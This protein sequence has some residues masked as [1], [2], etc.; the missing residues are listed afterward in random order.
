LLRRDLVL[1]GSCLA[2]TSNSLPSDLYFFASANGVAT[3][4]PFGARGVSLGQYPERLLD[5]VMG[6][7]AIYPMFPPRTIDDFPE[8]EESIDLVDGG[9]AH[10][11]PIEAAVEWGATHVL[12]I[13]ASP[14]ERH[15]R[16]NFVQNV[17]AAF[18]HLYAQ[19]QQI[20]IFTL[21]P[22]APHL[23]VLD[24]AGNLVEASIDKGFREAGEKASFR[25]ELGEPVFWEAGSLK[26]ASAEP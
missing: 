18:N 21:S 4:R 17:S 1:T 11:S 2:Q 10:N 6:S 24:F 8:R 23:C 12:L 22:S 9:F 3:S 26:T 13:Q 7:G 15:E 19:A 25:K 14:E 16:S 5:V 20:V